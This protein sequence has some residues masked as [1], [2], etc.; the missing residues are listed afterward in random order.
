MDDR[1]IARCCGASALASGRPGFS[2]CSIKP[3]RCRPGWGDEVSI[4]ALP[5]NRHGGRAPHFAMGGPHGGGGPHGTPLRLG[6]RSRQG[7]G[8][9]AEH[10]FTVRGSGKSV[11]RCHR[12]VLAYWKFESISLQRRV[13]RTFA[14]R[15]CPR[16]MGADGAFTNRR[17]TVGTALAGRGNQPFLCSAARAQANRVADRRDGIHLERW[18]AAWSLALGNDQRSNRNLAWWLMHEHPARLNVVYETGTRV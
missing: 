15:R 16:P 1:G 7:G 9:P 14:S 6:T 18:S 11:A 10:R 4:V 5:A 13:R 3:D 12:T 2:V 8:R 17:A